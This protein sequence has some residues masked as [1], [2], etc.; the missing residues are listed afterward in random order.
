MGAFEVPVSGISVGDQMY[1]VVST[2]HSN[3]RTT[4][5]SVLTKFTP[6]ATFKP[7]RTI[8][9]LPEG[10][11]VKMSMHTETGSM[12]GLPPDGP[13]II[14]WGTGVYR[15]SNAYLSI[16]PAANFETRKGTRYFARLNNAGGPVWS[17]KESDAKPIAENGTMG[18]L[19][20]TWCKDLGVWLMA[21]DSRAP[22]PRGILFSLL[23]H[24]VGTV[25]RAANRIQCSS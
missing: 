14:I 22:A 1:V 5:R 10:R 17:E 12:A 15:K 16:V 20:V 11:F 23:P 18:D 8:S 4:D 25:E 19:S 24:A 21:Y 3:D 13:F 7:L 6:P 9:Q 2:N